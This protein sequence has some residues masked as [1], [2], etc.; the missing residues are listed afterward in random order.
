M[1]SLKENI[2]E[3]L[4][5]SGNIPKGKLKLALDIQKEKKLPL[6]KVLVDEGI[7]AEDNLSSLFSGRLYMPTL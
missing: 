2:T 4:H 3:I 1:L 5:K 7:I 6:R